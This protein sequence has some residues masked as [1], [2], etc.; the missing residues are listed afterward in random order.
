MKTIIAAA[1]VLMVAGAACGG[2]GA[3]ARCERC[4]RIFGAEV[5]ESAL[6]RDPDFRA[7]GMFQ[8]CQECLDATMNANEQKAYEGVAL[9]YKANSIAHNRAVR[10]FGGGPDLVHGP[11]ASRRARRLQPAL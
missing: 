7:R 3:P 1:C 9:K 2:E 5:R 4:G 6:S 11:Q 10:A 8:K